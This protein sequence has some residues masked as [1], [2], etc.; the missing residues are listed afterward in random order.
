M[1]LATT[2]STSAS[3]NTMTG[4]LPPSSRCTRV[5]VAAAAVATAWPAATLPVSD[6]MATS[7]CSTS[8]APAV[9][10]WPQTTLSTPGGR[11]SSVISASL[12]AGQR[13][14]LAGLEHD[15]VAGGQRGPE[16]PGGHVE[17]VVPRRDRGDDPERVTTDHRGVARLV[18]A[19][20]LALEEAAGRGEEAP[21]VQGQVHLEL[22]D[23]DGLADV[24]ALDRAQ[25]VHVVLDGVG[26]RVQHLG[27]LAGRAG[28][29]VRRRRPGPRRRRRRRRRR[30]WRAPSR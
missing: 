5:S 3:S 27:A 22:D 16:L 11:M 21:V 26:H 13:R 9:S 2:A 10:P 28:R 12:S 20:G 30:R 14:E 8:A 25:L 29:P 19:G 1:R 23:R 24:L 15:G 17:R 4:A 18:L 6:A 7:G